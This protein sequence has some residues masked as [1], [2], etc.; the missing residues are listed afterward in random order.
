MATAGVGPPTA[1]FLIET[2]VDMLSGVVD[3]MLLSYTIM[4]S[5]NIYNRE[6]IVCIYSFLISTYIFYLT[7]INSGHQIKLYITDSSLTIR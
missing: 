7:I 4:D 6:L 1:R 3:D 2:E 5:I